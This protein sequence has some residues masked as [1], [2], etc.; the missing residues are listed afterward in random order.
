MKK[1]IIVLTL[2]LVGCGGVDIFH[3]KPELVQ[4]PILQVTPPEPVQQLPVEWV[5]VRRETS[6]A[7]FNEIE[8]KGGTVALFAITPQGYV[9][10]SM[11]MAELRRYIKQ[12]NATVITLKQYYE[13]QPVPKID[14]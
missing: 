14:K 4:K 11:N 6:E 3:T 9:N 2:L 8:A 5:V 12:Q 10:L 13:K 1:L 7:I